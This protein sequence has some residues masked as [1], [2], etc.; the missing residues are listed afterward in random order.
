MSFADSFFLL[1]FFYI[2]LSC[3]VLM[4]DKPVNAAEA[5]AH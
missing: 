1:T 3:L 4:V 2:A 5:G